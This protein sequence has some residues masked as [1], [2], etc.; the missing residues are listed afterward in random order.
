MNLPNTISAARIVTAPLVAILPFLPNPTWRA[1]GFLL[2]L[3]SAIS[4]HIDGRIARSR[5]LV[6]DLG[7]LLDPIADKLL[8]VATFIPTFVMM[9]PDGDWLL[10]LIPGIEG[11]STYP[12]RTFGV[13]AVWF[14]WWILLPI[15]ARE[16]FIT[17]FRTYAKARGVIVPAQPLGR[18]KA[19]FQYIWMGAAYFWF[20]QRLLMDQGRFTGAGADLTAQL[21]GSLGTIAM[22]VAFVLT[23]GSL[24]GY[25]RKHADVFT[26][27]RTS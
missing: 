6:T 21:V 9:A 27:P 16:I 25:L 14:P 22:G 26:R 17:W 2:F 20:T 3:S 7:K 23:L 19:V 15:V 5:G 8:L 12:F 24:T 10:G 4:D 1:V 18:W 11:R 13:E